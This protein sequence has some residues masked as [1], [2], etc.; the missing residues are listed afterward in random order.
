MKI[1]DVYFE[2]AQ[3]IISSISY[4]TSQTVTYTYFSRDNGIFFGAK[5]LDNII[6]KYV[7]GKSPY[8]LLTLPEKQAFEPNSIIMQVIFGYSN[9]DT[10]NN[11]MM[12][13]TELLGLLSMTK[14]AYNM[15]KIVELTSAPVYDFSARHYPSELAPYIALAAYIGG[16]AGTSTQAGCDAISNYTGEPY[17]SPVGTTPHAL[18]CMMPETGLYSEILNT[19]LFALKFPNK[20]AIVLND[21]SGQ[22]LNV[23]AQACKTLGKLDNFWGVRLDT[24]GERTDL[25]FSPDIANDPESLTKQEN[26]WYYGPGVSV[27]L[28]RAIKKVIVANGCPDAKI[29]VSSGFNL[30]KT[31]FFH[32]WDAPFDAIGTG[33][34]VEFG[35]ITADI[36]KVNNK[37]VVKAGREWL[38]GKSQKD[39]GLVTFTS[40]KNSTYDA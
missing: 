8:I 6:K 7:G 36:T 30:E 14:T 40:N 1:Y 19:L 27:K 9:T 23:T 25:V 17:N 33:S 16:A 38:Y 13:E 26:Q 10:M 5:L 39:N 24:C 32:T 12:A 15:S 31:K 22:E 2:N 34:F 37:R 29:M 18:S 3:K 20:P 35:R 11:F 4:K 21:Y 28:C